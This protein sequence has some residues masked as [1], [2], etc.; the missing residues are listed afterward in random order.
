MKQIPKGAVEQQLKEA[1]EQAPQPQEDT[2]AFCP[3]SLGDWLALCRQAGV[4]HVAA[5]LTATLLREDCLSFDTPGDHQTRLRDAMLTIERAKL[6]LHMAR[7]DCCASIGIKYHMAQ[8]QWEWRPDFGNIIL[9]DPRAVDIL[10]EY[11][12]REVPV[13]R[14]PWVNAINVDS[15]AVEYRAFVND[16]RIAGISSYYPQRPLPHFPQHIREI[17]EQTQKLINC[18]QP[19]FLWPMTN[20]PD[21]T[22]PAGVHFTADFISTVDGIRFLEG[23]PPHQMGAH[24]CCF[25]PFEISGLALIDRNKQHSP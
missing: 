2:T 23:G 16:G 19:P 22:D 14:R 17:N 13:W 3:I 25:R 15:Y 1:M 10:F 21:D 5:E 11:P 12:R 6:P 7:L 18:A 9:D 4:P 20:L 24:P 8:G